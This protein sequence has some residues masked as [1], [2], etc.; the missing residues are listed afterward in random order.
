VDAGRVRGVREGHRVHGADRPGALALSRYCLDTSAYSR[1]NQGD[2]RITELVDGADWIGVP[3]VAVGEL[4]VGFFAGSRSARNEAQLD[5]FLA[6]PTVEELPIDREVARIYAE[7]L[8]ALKAAGT[9][10][11]TNDVWIAAASARAGVPLL[12]FDDHFQAIGRI[13]TILLRPAE[14]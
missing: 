10:L 7:I 1:L 14:A 9:P 5:E 3:S 6:D 2:S 13:G 8:V 4:L 11:P 12:T